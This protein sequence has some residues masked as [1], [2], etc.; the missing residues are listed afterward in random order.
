MLVDLWL[1]ALKSP[2]GLKIETDNRQLLRAHLYKVRAEA[3]NLDL[4]SLV[5]V[6]PDQSDELWLVHKHAHSL[7]ADNQSNVEPL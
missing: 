4:E 5:I 1:R 3:G 2:H 7:G 6:L